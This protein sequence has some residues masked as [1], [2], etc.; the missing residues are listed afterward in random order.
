MKKRQCPPRRTLFNAGMTV[1]LHLS[2]MFTCSLLLFLVGYI[3]FRGIP[4]ISWQF[5]TTS[6][7]ILKGTV[8]ILPAICNTL[9]V[10]A[11]SL[12][13]VLPL[14]VGAAIYLTEYARNRKLVSAIEFA[15]ETLAGI[16]SIIYALVG[17]IIFCESLGLG[18]TLLSGSLTL[19]I[20][21]LPTVIRSTQE[22]LK[23]VP[24]SYREGALGLGSGKWHMIRTVV[25]PSS[26]DGI[27]T[28]CI[29]SIGRIVGESAVLMYAAGMSTA[30][31]NFSSIENFM[32]SSGATLSVALYVFAKERADFAAAF[33][34]ATILLLLTVLINFAASFAAKKL[35]RQ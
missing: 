12:I 5:L 34:I 6:E 13:I 27:V 16:P 10:I 31:Q 7:S 23:T 25:L 9:Y 14:G 18:K 30:M 28:G 2:A 20:M 29:L 26:M 21:T 33:S 8:G 19:V 11:V 3:C 32:R 4:G 35:R 24:M 17:T 15:T 22:S 1:L